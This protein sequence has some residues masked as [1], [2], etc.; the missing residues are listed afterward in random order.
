MSTVFPNNNLPTASQPW[1]REVT[2]QLSTLI[3]TVE[4]SQIN[5]TARDNQLNSSI[6]SLNSTVAS[7][8]SLIQNVSSTYTYAVSL[9]EEI[10]L[11]AGTAENVLQTTISIPVTIP[12]GTGSR[13]VTV[14]AFGDTDLKVFPQAD[15]STRI[16]VLF[17]VIKD[18]TVLGSMSTYCGVNPSFNWDLDTNVTAIMGGGSLVSTGQ[19]SVNTSG[20]YSVTIKATA[21]KVRPGG[22][23]NFEGNMRITSALALVGN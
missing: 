16:T 17:E 6:T 18:S 23:L 10:E 14:I 15:G 20:N 7:L 19:F 8:Q 11:T 5:N 12:P 22:T 9:S 1:G 3:Q 4:S 2:R 21:K 13:T